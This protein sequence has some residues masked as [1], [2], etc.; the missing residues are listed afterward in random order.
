MTNYFERKTK[1][2]QESLEKKRETIQQLEIFLD[3]LKDYDKKT[4]S[5]NFFKKYYSS[6]KHASGVSKTWYPHKTYDGNTYHYIYF[7]NDCSVRIIN[8]STESIIIEIEKVLERY[9]IGETDSLEKILVFE[10]TSDDSF[11]KDLQDF[12][13]KYPGIDSFIFIEAIE[14]NRYRLN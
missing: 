8:K 3:N 2:Y 11:F 9:K 5:V 4:I 1:E 13:N 14:Q 7:A 12:K 6:E 10:N